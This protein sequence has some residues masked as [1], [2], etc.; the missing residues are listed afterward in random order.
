M[1]KLI[2]PFDKSLVEP[3]NK[4][5]YAKY[6]E[7]KGRRIDPEEQPELADEWRQHYNTE[8][9]KK[10]GQGH[11]TST[12]PSRLLGAKPNDSILPCPDNAPPCCFDSL[13]ANCGHKNRKFKLTLPEAQ[14]SIAPA[15]IP[16]A[17][18]T[19]PSGVI[20]VLAGEGSKPETINVKLSV[21]PCGRG[22]TIPKTIVVSPTPLA[23][24]IKKW[25]AAELMFQVYCKELNL[26]TRPFDYLFPCDIPPKTYQVYIDVCEGKNQ[27]Y[28]LI[29]VHPEIKWNIAVNI[30]FGGRKQTYGPDIANLEK[31]MDTSRVDKEGL[32]GKVSVEFDGETTELAYQFENYV[33]TAIQFIRTADRVAKHAQWVFNHFGNVS[34]GILWPNLEI[35]Y[36]YS[37]EESIEKYNVGCIWALTFE[38]KP[39]I[40]AYITLDILDW[41]IGALKGVPLGATLQKLKRRAEKGFGEEDSKFKAKAKLA[42]EFT[43]KAEGGTKLEFRKKTPMDDSVQAKGE[44]DVKLPAKIEGIASTDIEAWIV[45]I[46]A[47][48]IVGGK[49]AFGIRGTA[50]HDDKG[51]FVLGQGY[52]SGLVVYYVLYLKV[53]AVIGK[54]RKRKTGR[55]EVET[56]SGQKPESKEEMKSETQ[57][58]DPKSWPE[59]PDKLYVIKS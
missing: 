46:S 56:G 20:K 22:K 30:N 42:V 32:A 10:K 50:S 29:E 5:F 14:Q 18:T 41:M 57:L 55:T 51:V 2:M 37:T 49:T 44:V 34:W 58:L 13:T 17:G 19:G 27:C 15:L 59:K 33:Q 25:T 3:A 21:P 54:P 38:A 26:L 39:L 40:G 9:R 8:A 12:K 7:L 53:G 24:D 28:F 23:S 31:M 43:V 47:A 6:P 1:T 35:A 16:Q 48:A 45:S 11:A 52:F 36:N 4:A